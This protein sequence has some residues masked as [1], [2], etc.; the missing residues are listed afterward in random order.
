MSIIFFLSK[1]FPYNGF[2]PG[3]G[4]MAHKQSSAMP[5][6]YFLSGSK[7]PNFILRLDWRHDSKLGTALVSVAP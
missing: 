3:F 6:L 7:K 1:T 5:W 4:I 2:V